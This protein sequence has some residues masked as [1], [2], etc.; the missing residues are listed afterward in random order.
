MDSGCLAAEYPIFTEIFEI[1]PLSLCNGLRQGFQ[2]KRLDGQ[3]GP[4]SDMTDTTHLQVL[5][6]A[7]CCLL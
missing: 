2:K 7:Y 6:H 4:V 1:D 3:V 5:P